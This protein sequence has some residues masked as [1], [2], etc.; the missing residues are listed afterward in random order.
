MHTYVEAEQYI[1]P[2]LEAGLIAAI[3]ITPDVYWQ[4]LDF[5]PDNPLDGFAVH[6]KS[7]D[8]LANAIVADNPVPLGGELDGA[9]PTTD[10]V[11]AARTLGEL[12]QQRSLAQYL[13][14]C[15]QRQREGE[16]AAVL[17]ELI[18]ERGAAV[19]GAI[20]ATR[21]GNLLWGDVLVAS[22]L[23]Q[24][25]DAL[26]AKES[27]RETLGI[28]TGH[29]DLDRTLNGLNV[30]LYVL[31]GA[32]GVGKTSL[33][34]QWACHAAEELPVLYVTYENSPASLV[35][36]AIGRMAGV[37]PADVERGRADLRKFQEGAQVF[38]AV[39]SRLAFVEGNQ[40]TT[41][42]YIQG[43][44][45]QAMAR[46]GASRC[47]VVVDYL[48]RMAHA[49]GSGYGT[50]RENVS[51]LTLGL[52][53]L[54]TRLDSPVLAISSLSRG[55][56]NY[57]KPTLESLKES[58]DLE[59]TA[60]VVLLLGAREDA[61]GTRGARP[62]DL[63][64]AKNRYGEADRKVGLIFKPALGDFREEARE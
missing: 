52:R 8:D 49:S 3:R 37:A 23:E 27:G 16:S 50:L 51:A 54:A 29:Q 9:D 43:R 20:A 28:A 7:W 41:T 12:Y 40:R 11:G 46:H 42:A 61:V 38:R 39:A 24:A 55:Q 17:M 47:L 35:L 22:V 56:G 2:N 53:E 48:Q 59:F 32:P 60:D 44:A 21:S 5:L 36:K 57:G 15:L 6:W 30:G 18:L 10:P 64:V 34:L 13:Q 19:Q 33:A 26:E 63:L 45:R 14:E 58:G 1:A 4:I 62:V 25:K 31:G